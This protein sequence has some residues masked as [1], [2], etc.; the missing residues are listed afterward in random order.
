MNRRLQLTAEAGQ[1]AS[2]SFLRSCGS[3]AAAVRRSSLR[4]QA[5]ASARGVGG[6]LVT[7]RSSRPDLN[8]HGPDL[9]KACRARHVLHRTYGISA[10]QRTIIKCPRSK[11]NHLPTQVCC[12][13][14]FTLAAHHDRA[15]RQVNPANHGRMRRHAGTGR[16][17]GVVPAYTPAGRAS[18]PAWV[19]GGADAV[20]APIAVKRLSGG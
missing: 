20:D 2:G 4:C 5:A 15:A 6:R 19:G 8:P 13:P 3:A 11:L 16:R 12:P 10:G 17:N 14:T 1:G 9:R 7:V 18:W